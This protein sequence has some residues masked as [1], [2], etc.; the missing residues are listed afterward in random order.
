VPTLQSPRD[1]LIG[2]FHAAVAAVQADA[3]LPPHLAALRLAQI[4]RCLLVVGAGKA[5]AA[6]AACVEAQLPEVELSGLV[7]TRHGHGVPTRRIEVIEAG[8]PL[9]DAAGLAAAKRLYDQVRAAGP[10]DQVLALISGG[11][12]SLLSL[13]VEGVSLADLQTVMHALLN[14][15]AAIAE[16]NTV[17]KHLSRSLGGRLAAVCRARVTALLISDVS[18]DDPAVIASGPFAPDPST[19]ADALAILARWKIDAPASVLRHLQ[20]G[21]AGEWTETPRAET[22]KPGAACFER[23]AH[24]VIANGRTALLAAADFWRARGIRPVILGDTFSGEAREVAQAFAAL[25]REIRQFN[26]PWTAPLVLLSGGETSVSVAGKDG[27]TGRGGRNSEFL[28][29]LAIALDGLAGVH[30]LAADSDGIDG[31]QDNAGAIIA[32][33]SLARAA[34]LGIDAGTQLAA[35]DAYGFFAGLDDLLLTG[36]T[37]TNVNDFRAILIV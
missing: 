2:S 23:V 19:F 3:L 17:R 35:H 33:D 21:V 24:H 11:G 1:L 32:P 20:A 14:S 25:T 29:A 16:I 37:R 5:A 4:P 34:A 28:L 10:E 36:P 9:P 15:G 6:M 7:I 18:G 13:P 30:A 26:N 12:S 27:D 22:P 8:H 31:T